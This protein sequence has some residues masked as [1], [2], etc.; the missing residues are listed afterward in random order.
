MKMRKCPNC[1]SDMI[2]LD[3]QLITCGSTVCDQN[4][5]DKESDLIF[6]QESKDLKEN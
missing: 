6:E 5:S 3:P 4:L 2:G 1:A